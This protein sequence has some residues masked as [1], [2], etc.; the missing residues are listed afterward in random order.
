MSWIRISATLRR[1]FYFFA[2][3]DH[4]VDLFFWPTFDIFLWGMASLWIQRQDPLMSTLALG[5][6]SALV[7]WQVVW[8]S[9]YEVC[10]NVLQE[11]W[12]RNLIN[13][14]STPLQWRE[15]VVAL[16]IIGIGK[17][18]ITLA[19]GG[20]VVFLLYGL[21]VF[22]LGVALIPFCLSLLISGW[23]IGFFTA[24]L[25]VY[26]GQ[27]LQMLSWMIG[28]G[29]MPFSAVFY[30][31]EALPHWA[32]VISSALPMSYIFEGMRALIHTGVVP[33]GALGLSLELNA[34]YLAAMLVLFRFFFEKS[35]VKGLARL[36]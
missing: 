4:T 2:R 18:I 8:R 1:Y 29:F 16:M 10:V 28:Y 22:S 32:Q 24:S 15:W 7:L 25:T 36:E 30:P 21:N 6:L 5:M 19:F 23:W 33:W 20:M 31:V 27:R 26:F 17:A 34:L 9:T 12:S 3:L 13:L 14:F 35:R 11:L